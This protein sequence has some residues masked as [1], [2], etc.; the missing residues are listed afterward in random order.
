MKNLKIL[1]VDSDIT[2]V[3]NIQNLFLNFFITD[4]TIEDDASSALS[5]YKKNNFDLVIVNLDRY[6]QNSFNFI[7]NI[8]YIYN[9]QVC[10]IITELDNK[11][12][13]I[14]AIE[15]RVHYLLDKPIQSNIFEKIIKECYIEINQN[16][17]ALLSNSL[18]VQYKHAIDSRSILSKTNIKGEITYANNLFYKISQFTKEE[19]LGQNHNILKHPDMDMAVLKKMWETIQSK[20]EWRGIIKNK[21]KDGKEYIWDSLIIPLLDTHNNI[22][23]Y[24]G[25]R[26]DITKLEHYKNNLQ[27]QLNMAINDIEETQKEVVFTMGAIAETRSKETA[28]HV[29]R[30][31]E[32]SFLLA[33]LAGVSKENTLLLKL[34]SPMHDI[35]KVGIPDAILNKPAKLTKEEFKIMQ[36]YA[37]VGYEMLKN[38]NKEI[39]QTSAI[40]AHEHHEKW[41]G[42]GYPRGLKKENI[43]I[44]GRITAICDVFDALGSN[45]CYKKAW[46][47][48]EILEYLK[49]Q[50]YKHF[51]PRLV[52]LFLVNIKKF[53]TIKECYI[54]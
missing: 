2:N 17:A 19:C 25:I 27:L 42:T 3:Q 13:L 4:L 38:S 7:K 12:H 48:E 9:E 34:A 53:L 41:D 46:D 50:K 36:S 6:T 45:R 28:N 1:Y 44:Y 8:K 37:T 31:A 5:L 15:L 43:H 40:V 16:K 20:K 29:K 30:V 22:I 52:D 32:Y 21:S 33:K 14:K 49:N 10:I 18:L 47:I 23:E 11:D 39:L 24:I 35:G 26:H 54:D 51:D